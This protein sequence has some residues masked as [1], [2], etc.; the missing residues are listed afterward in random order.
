MKQ[1]VIALMASWCAAWAGVANATDAERPAAFSRSAADFVRE[2]IRIGINIGNTLDTPS[3][4]ETEWGNFPVTPELVRLYRAK[5]FDAVRIPVTWLSHFDIADPR[6]RIDPVFLARVREVA[7]MVLAE[8]MVAVVNVHH[9]GGYHRWNGW[10]LSVDGRNEARNEGILRD[11]WTQ[12]A[13]KFRDVGERLV[14]E[15]FNEV[16]KARDYAGP[17]GSQGGR[18]D[19]TGRP[20]YCA[21]LN[22]YAR[23]FREA[24][25][26]TGGNNA[27]RYLM[28]PTYAAGFSEAACAGWRSPDASDD[29]IIA[30]VHCYEPGDFCLRGTKTDYD[31]K[32]VQAKLDEYLPRFRRH[33]TEKGIPLILGEVNAV[34]GYRDA[35]KKVNNDC[36]RIRWAAHYVSEARRFGFPVFVWENGGVP[37]TDMGL[38]DRRRVAWS[39]EAL[40]DAFVLSA[41][42]EPTP[43][44][45]EELCL[46]VS[47]GAARRQ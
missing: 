21:A 38:V 37:F 41:K 15:G 45:I 7:D 1:S 46:R 33:F 16:S 12:I 10:W 11:L 31:R 32:L 35:A 26:A 44:K 17:D 18:E 39:H 40:V 25:R 5:G 24:V 42:G 20:E 13:E 22:R 27:K 4:K 3:G 14:F 36:D 43:E 8:G 2:E 9:D 6:H 34:C 29:H 47:K 23:A 19:W 28:V 30:T